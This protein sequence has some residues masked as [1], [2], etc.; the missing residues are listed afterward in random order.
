MEHFLFSEESGQGLA[1]YAMLLVMMSI[2]AVLLVTIIGEKNKENFD[3][4]GIFDQHESLEYK[5]M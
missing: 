4:N 3:I 5:D 2:A 1:E